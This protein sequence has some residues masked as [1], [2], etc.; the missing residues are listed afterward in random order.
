MNRSEIRELQVRIA[1][2]AAAGPAKVYLAVDGVFG[3]KTKVALK[4]FQRAYGL[5]Q[6]GVVRPATVKVL[7][8]LEAADESTVHFRWAEFV[9]H[10][11]SC[12]A[13]GKVGAA[14][15]RQNVRRQM[16][17]LEAL[18]KKA[19]DFPM[20]VASGFRSVH[21]NA[22]IGG[23]KNSQH[24]YGIAADIYVP[25]VDSGRLAELAKS[26]GFSGVK[27]YGSFA[28][29]HLDSRVEYTYR[30]QRWWWPA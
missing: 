15:V 8:R 6:D 7:A 23:E 12:F 14:R 16:Y 27:A 4:R 3:P 17:K 21:H 19:G 2:W 5:A 24:M 11:G 9:S 1:G 30:A 29:V 18:R 20:R 10:D 25:L 26:C 22:A 28:H 13:G